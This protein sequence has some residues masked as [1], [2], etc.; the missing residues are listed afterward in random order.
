MT[1]IL[2]VDDDESSVFAFAQSLREAGC[3]VRSALDAQ[4]GFEAIA[5]SEPAAIL[6]DLHLPV[7]DG[8]EFLRRLRSTASGRHVPVAIVTSDYLV[9]DD[10]VD[11]LRALGAEIYF[12]PLWAEDVVRV[13][14][15]LVEIPQSAE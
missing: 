8:R 7:V 1:E 14:T 2:I 3:Q 5:F 12:K 15:T 4:H 10:V 13:V 6:L 11:D 9:D